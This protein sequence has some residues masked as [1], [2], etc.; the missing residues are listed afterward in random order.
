MWGGHTLSL[1]GEA[2]RVRVGLAILGDVRL[3]MRRRQERL[4]LQCYRMR[5]SVISSSNDVQLV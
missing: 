4:K 3:G 5:P 2:I 1:S